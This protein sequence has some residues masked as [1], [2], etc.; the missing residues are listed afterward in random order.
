MKR[1]SALWREALQFA[2]PRMLTEQMAL[3]DRN[4]TTALLGS[5]LAALITAL[6][7]R[8]AVGNDDVWWWAIVTCALGTAGLLARRGLPHPRAANG[9]LKYAQAMRVVWLFNGG[10]WGAAALLFINAAE[11]S[12]I[13]ILVGVTAGMGSAAVA[14]FGPNWPMAVV[15]WLSC[16]PPLVWALL[17]TGDPFGIMMG[18]A[19]ALYLV[20]MLV[21]A[22][23][24][25]RMGRRAIDLYFE[26]EGLVQRLRDQTQRALEARQLAEEA[27]LEAEEANR[28]K[29]LFLASA[30]HDLRQPLHAA[31]LFLGSLARSG[32]NARQMQ[33]LDHIQSSTAAASDM[34]NTLMNFSKVDAG[35][36]QS[37]PQRF[38]LQPLFHKLERELAPWAAQKGLAFRLRDTGLVLFADPGLVEL[39]LRNLLL[40]A[41]RYTERGGV[42]LGCRVRAGR[43]VVE[44]WDTG[45]GIE[46]AAHR[47][48]FREFHQLGNPERDRRKGLGLGLA[49]V[50]GLA[51]AMSVDV[52]LAS[53]PGRG[54]VFRLTLPISEVV[55]GA[56]K[57]TDPT[58]W[59]AS[60][61]TGFR[62]LLIE[63]DTAVREAMVDLMAQWGV[64]C[65]AVGTPQAALD[66]LA[67]FSPDA[68]LADY[69]L[70][71]H[72]TGL[73]AVLAIRER[74]D[75]S[76]PAALITGDTS[77]ARLQEASEAGLGL[78]HKPV[79]ADRLQALLRDLVHAARCT[80][81]GGVAAN[82][83][84]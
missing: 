49:I 71:G 73:R 77:F 14:V 4:I 18:L 8:F 65:E 16:L 54:S 80:W 31:S 28:A 19:A 47:A 50:E 11:P 30:S 60:G 23:H 13:N 21:Y 70:C 36:I 10:A 52:D 24:T 57:A 35:V 58:G 64:C 69:R 40:N 37:H 55:T 76:V 17:R 82:E 61:L 42:L 56:A 48:I 63:D 43:A 51:R 5:M 26:N 39:I 46:P 75:R 62:V 78:L 33:L 20:V 68:V 34:L 25:S 79:S 27:Q 12:S 9:A 1:L 53:R 72:W 83:R 22:Y 2:P 41:I 38:A 44:V 84:L 3:L 59:A 67:R 15:Y 81:T 45:I 66:M 6:A 74:L 7:F 29:T 32:L